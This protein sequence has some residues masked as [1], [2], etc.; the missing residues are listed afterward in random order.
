MSDSVNESMSDEAVYRTAPA[1]PG[2]LI[3][4]GMFQM[5]LRRCQMV[6]GRFF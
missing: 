3:M 2:L 4:S 1:T 5:V 6:P